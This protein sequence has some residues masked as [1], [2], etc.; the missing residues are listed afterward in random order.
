MMTDVFS[1]DMSTNIIK[2]NEVISSYETDIRLS[3][4]NM[5]KVIL[6]LE[7]SFGEANFKEDFILFRNANIDENS[8]CIYINKF[9]CAF[10]KTY[11]RQ[12]PHTYLLK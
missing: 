8:A 7:K 5:L 3:L 9:D 6:E 10:L 1:F 12:Q 11:E 4:H 2:N